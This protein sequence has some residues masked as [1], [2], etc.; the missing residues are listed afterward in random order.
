LYPNCPASLSVIF[1][2]WFL[3][4]I[5]EMDTR[6][7]SSCDSLPIHSFHAATQSA[8][9]TFVEDLGASSSREFLDVYSSD[10]TIAETRWPKIDLVEVGWPISETKWGKASASKQ[11]FQSEGAQSL[12]RRGMI[13]QEHL[14]SADDY[15]DISIAEARWPKIEM[16]E[17]GW[18][19]SVS[20]G[21]SDG[22][23]EIDLAEYPWATG[24]IEWGSEPM[25]DRLSQPT[26]A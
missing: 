22:H 8:G 10:I 20:S 1:I 26:G 15:L 13:N 9:E 17:I 14:L 23:L 12:I 25:L 4:E 3:L 7:N 18:Q 11:P 21:V 2:C 19:S 16:V 5:R 6:L 24:D